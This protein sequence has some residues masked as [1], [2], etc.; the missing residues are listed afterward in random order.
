M[1]PLFLVIVALFSGSV[2][3]QNRAEKISAED[4]LHCNTS[5]VLKSELIVRGK[6]MDAETGKPIGNARLNYDLFD[7]ELMHGAVDEKGNYTLVL[8][9]DELGAPVRLIFKVKGYKKFVARRINK[10]AG[11]VNVDVYLKP[12]ESSEHSAAD[13]RYI[14]SDDP[15]NTLVIRMQ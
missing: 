14:M 2:F 3:A 13:I 7:K 1:K 15:Y 11:Q 8:K 4:H 9:K 12:L 6:I 5:Q 10:H